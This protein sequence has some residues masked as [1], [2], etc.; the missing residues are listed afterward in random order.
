MVVAGFDNKQGAINQL[1]PCD[2]QSNDQSDD[3][4]PPSY[5][6]WPTHSSALPPSP[7]ELHMHIML[8]SNEYCLHKKA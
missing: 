1:M 2:H 8:L 6:F 5:N 7:S 3:H 4:G